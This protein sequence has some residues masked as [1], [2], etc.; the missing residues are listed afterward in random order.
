MENWI[1]L[2]F[3]EWVLIEKAARSMVTKLRR[4]CQV[5]KWLRRKMRN[6]GLQTEF[7]HL[8][9]ALMADHT[10]SWLSF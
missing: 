8:R 9:M 4:V 5:R 3:V 7:Q 10:F 2:I 1:E 6:Q